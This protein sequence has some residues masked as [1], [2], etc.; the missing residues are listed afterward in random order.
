[1][2]GALRA[3]SPFFGEDRRRLLVVQGVA[4]TVVPPV[5]NETFARRQPLVRLWRV[6]G[7]HLTDRARP[8]VIARALAWLRQ[9]P[10]TPPADAPPTPDIR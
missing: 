8:I 5:M 7:G 1:M 3:Y 2:P 9:A 10:S 4:D 6:P